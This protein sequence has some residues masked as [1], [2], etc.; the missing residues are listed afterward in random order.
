[1]EYLLG[2]G[3]LIA[4]NAPYLVGFIMPPFVEVLNKD[5]KKSNERFLVALIACF[6]VSI[7]L[8]WNAIAYGTPEQLFTY[9]GI[10]FTECMVIFKLYFSDSWL[11]GTIQDKI[12]SNHGDVAP[13]TE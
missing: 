8:H 13:L 12:N 5:V 10:I 1:M 11:R 3:S 9:A 2:L 6:T 4:L 7:L